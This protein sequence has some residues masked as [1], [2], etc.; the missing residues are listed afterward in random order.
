MNG[1]LSE[2]INYLFF[3]DH[4]DLLFSRAFVVSAKKKTQRSVFALQTILQILSKKEVS[5]VKRSAFSAL[6]SPLAEVIP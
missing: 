4:P 6:F 3:G 1:T 5:A 2:F